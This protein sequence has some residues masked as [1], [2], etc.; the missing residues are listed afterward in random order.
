MWKQKRKRKNQRQKTL[1]NKSTTIYLGICNQRELTLLTLKNTIEM[2][3]C[4]KRRGKLYFL[5]VDAFTMLSMG[6]TLSQ[7]NTGI[8]SSLPLTLKHPESLQSQPYLGHERLWGRGS[9]RGQRKG[10]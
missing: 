10:S 3:H 6:T 9:R 8:Y 2:V 1:T 7:S 5:L 4:G